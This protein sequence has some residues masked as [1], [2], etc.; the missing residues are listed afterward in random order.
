MFTIAHLAAGSK[1]KFV[2][3]D[4]YYKINQGAARPFLTGR[5]LVSLDHFLMLLHNPCKRKL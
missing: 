3:V 1:E 5:A 2:I 4:S